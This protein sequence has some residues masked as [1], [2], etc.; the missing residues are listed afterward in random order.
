MVTSVILSKLNRRKIIK[1]LGQFASIIIITLLAVCLAVGLNSS[2]RTLEKKLDVLLEGSNYA[3]GSI[4]SFSISEDEKILQQ[5]NYE[6]QKRLSLPVFSEDRKTELLITDGIATINKPYTNNYEGGVY[7]TYPFAERNNLKVGD[8]L[9]VTLNTIDFSSFNDE[10]DFSFLLERLDDDVIEGKENI[11]RK[12]SIELEFVIDGLMYHP[13][14]ITED[15]PISLDYNAF[16]NSL[17]NVIKDNFNNSETILKLL[18]FTGYEIYSTIL[19]KGNID[20]LNNH[21]YFKDKENTYIID[22]KYNP[23]LMQMESDITQA[24]QLTY[25]FPVIFI[26]VSILIIITTISQLIFKEKLNIATLK[27][28]GITNKEIYLH[29]ILLTIYLCLIGGIIGSIIGPL[30]IPSVMGIKYDLLYNVPSVN[31][32]FSLFTI[33]SNIFLFIIISFIVSFFILRKS[34]NTL[35]AVLIKDKGNHTF[36][37]SKVNIKSWSLKIALRN[38]S[39]NTFRSLMV[40]IG[41]GGCGALFIT[42]F[43]IDDTLTNTVKI[44]VHQNFN[45][46]A[47]ITFSDY[48]SDLKEQI[49]NLVLEYEEY[50][51]T[52]GSIDVEIHNTTN[53]FLIDNDTKFFNSGT[54][55]EVYISSKTAE[56]L[57]IK[58]N[59]VVN[60]KINSI[61]YEIKINKTIDIGFNHGVYI[62]KN[63]IN[64]NFNPTHAWVNVENQEL[65][66][67][68]ISKLEGVSTVG[69]RNEFLDYTDELLGPISII[70]ITLQVFAVLLGIVVLYNLALLNFKER[71]RDLATL[72]VLGL[73]NIEITKSIVYEMMVLAILGGIFG[74]IIGYPMLVLLLS[75]NEVD[76]VSYLYHL[77]PLSYTLTFLFTTT[78]A[79]IINVFLYKQIDKIKM[80]ES[81]KSVE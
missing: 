31:S 6:Y 10:I 42:G 53:I 24:Y 72:K 61:T 48:S 67:E 14:G 44:E 32:V 45:A 70:K 20:E 13:E 60:I 64:R 59:D 74:L 21:E 37:T 40:I 17:S 7:I 12:S 27:S 66:D 81:L 43:G 52:Q 51:I 4:I 39:Q 35:P 1:N 71:S 65:A 57:N 47:T 26:I 69:T 29:Y 75:I 15:E 56:K 76:F 5:L 23:G 63:L 2:A 11:F 22:S 28:I 77:T 34:V 58:E 79:F 8:A 73:T 41:V 36:K 16:T 78:T 80:V 33:F 25:V 50:T 38:I 55:N 19:F 49:E 62:P 54:F 3:D 46:D 9:V 68:E 30:L 18:P